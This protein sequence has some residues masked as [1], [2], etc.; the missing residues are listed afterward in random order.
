VLEDTDIYFPARKSVELY[1]L[2]NIATQ[3]SI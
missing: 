3:Q 1:S 2:P